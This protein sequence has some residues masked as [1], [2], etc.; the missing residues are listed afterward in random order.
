MGE[1]KAKN[2]NEK[3]KNVSAATQWDAMRKLQEEASRLS[4][5]GKSL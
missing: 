1:Q 3:S 5:F 4:T 2:V